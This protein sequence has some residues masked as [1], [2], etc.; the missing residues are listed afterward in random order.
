MS[1]TG[2][3]TETRTTA[4]LS[5]WRI[6]A[7]S[8]SAAASLALLTASQT[9]LTMLSHGHSF[10]RLL[11]WQL[12]CWGFWALAAPWIVRVSGHAR[13][14]RLVV[15]G[16]ALA[17]AHTL[18]VPLLAMWIQ[19]FL[20]FSY[21]FADLR[22]RWWFF[23]LVD[24]LLVTLIIVGG[25]SVA[26]YERTALLEVRESQLEAQLA[27]A[28]LD[29]LRLEIQPH[30]LFNT[31]NS[32]AALI[33]AND[34]VAALSMLLSLSDLM[35][36]TLDRTN[37]QMAPLGRELEL[38]RKYVELQ[39]ARFGTRLQVRYQIDGAAERCEIPVLLLQPLVENALRH[40]IA[41]RAKGG[42]LVVGASIDSSELLRLWVSDDG[43]GLRPGFDLSRDAGTGLGNTR[44]R[45]L[46][47]YG[48]RAELAIRRQ[49]GGGTVVEIAMPATGAVAGGLVESGAA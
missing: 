45:L 7:I 24:P 44:A 3:G 42:Q 32:L 21:D 8:S 16:I 15:I 9:Y 35:R 39:R 18:F 47:L 49:P 36:D 25:R 46:H 12:G 13:T 6:T 27:R 37:K 30:F 1:E 20:P 5:F 40:G 29:A 48:S 31:L 34:N 11:L 28:Q 22:Y 19:P 43:V 41:P 4:P 38:I 17:I 2:G 26:N 23:A 33:R 10:P 14:P